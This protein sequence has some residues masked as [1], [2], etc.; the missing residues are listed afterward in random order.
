MSSGTNAAAA[1]RLVGYA[2]A[3]AGDQR[4]DLQ[5]DALAR[6]GCARVFEDRPP[7]GGRAGR[8]GFAAALS[9]LRPGDTLVVWRLDRLGCTAR[10]LV[11]LLEGFGRAGVR[12]RSLHDGIDPATA[13][14]EAVLR[15]GAALAAMERDLVRERTGAGRSAARARGRCG[16]RPAVVTAAKLA[17]AR[18]LMADPGLTMG[19]VAGRVGVGRTTLYRALARETKQGLPVQA[20]RP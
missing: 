4:L 2:R 17:A 3:S 5:R 7:P 18:R 20:E 14:G 16:G 8:E 10:Q 13:T 1:G 9:C 15:F 6:A 19:E 12:L 11:G